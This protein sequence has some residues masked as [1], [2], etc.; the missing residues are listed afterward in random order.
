MS[1][2]SPG[3]VAAFVVL[4]ALFV[5]AADVVRTR[6]RARMLRALGVEPTFRRDLAGTALATGA[7]LLT[8]CTLL[9]AG[10]PAAPHAAPAGGRDVMLLVDVSRSMAVRD[11]APDRGAA[12]RLAAHF[13]AT[14]ADA[15]RVGVVAF[16]AD[17]HVL[18]PPTW[19]R[20]LVALY[21][22]ALDPDVVSGQGSD[23]SRALEVAASA[24]EQPR[25]PADVVL[26]SDGEGFEEDAA[27]ASALSTARRGG[28]RVHTVLLGTERGGTV[29]D[30]SGAPRSSA[31]PE[32][33][34]RIAAATGGT[35]RARRR[36]RG[37]SP[38]GPLAARHGHAGISG[39]GRSGVRVVRPLA[40]AGRPPGA[41]GRR[42]PGRP[43]VPMRT[44]TWRRIFLAAVAATC[45]SAG[46]AATT[47]TQARLARSGRA[48]ANG[49][50]ER[51]LRLATLPA[52]R[53]DAESE[54]LRGS[55][56]LALGRDA[57]AADVLGGAALRSGAVDTQ[58]RILHNLALAHLR[59]AA[60]AERPR[61]EIEARAS[62]LAGRAALR[63]R[64]GVAATSWNLTLAQRLVGGN[65]GSGAG[66]GDRGGVPL[67]A[68]GAAE[69][70]TSDAGA[71]A[72]LSGERAPL[73]RA[74]A[75]AIL[76]ALRGD[77][78]GSISRSLNRL[79]GGSGGRTDRGGPPW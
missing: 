31:H 55:A 2:A 74:E 40:R 10:G 54:Y 26:F 42:R 59:V 63:L 24:G 30:V 78:A 9:S 1:G 76:D 57:E 37:A 6:R 50:A 32:T 44:R 70:S 72:P 68:Q 43:E 3:L 52:A 36:R 27:L 71:E 48:L 33:L 21:V 34:A 4:G 20:G 29:P 60:G 73:S 65:E 22:D 66:S 45:T 61:R 13:I 14:E 39:D 58:R 51:A 77:E 28:V 62:V 53:T 17:A 38:A 12:A 67:M 64:P 15:A 23:L 69:G 5:A 56:L 79:L 49:E 11:V 8:G 46:L 47:R 18:L 35:G 41:P 16:A 19:D 7:V 75:A 25:R